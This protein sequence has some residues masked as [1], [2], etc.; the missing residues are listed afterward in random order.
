[1]PDLLPGGRRGSGISFPED[2]KS[3]IMRFP[4][5]L[6]MTPRVFI[7]SHS[8]IRTESELAHLKALFNTHVLA[9]HARPDRAPHS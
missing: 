6:G 7:C 1:M 3:F 8:L 4:V 2:L 5:K 9:R